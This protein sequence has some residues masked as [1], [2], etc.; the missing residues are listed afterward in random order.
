M[1]S[2][3]VRGSSASAAMMDTI[4]EMKLDQ[5][6][7]SRADGMFD[8]D[9]WEPFTSP[10][11]CE[12]GRAGEYRCNNID[13]VGFLRHQDAGSETRVGADLCE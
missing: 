2:L 9:R 12:D 6:A 1:A 5:W 10:L 8:L 11:P 7:K 4:K 13:M 3:L